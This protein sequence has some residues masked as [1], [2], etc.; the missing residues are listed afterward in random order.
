MRIGGLASGMDTDQLVSELMKA[1][2]MPLDKLMQNKV[3]TEWQRDSFREFNL[4][5]SN[6]RA[7]A[8]DLRFQSTF[9]A[10]SAT[11]SNTSSMTATTTANAVNGTYTA[12]V[13]SV[14]SPAKMHSAGTINNSTGVPANSTDLIGTA[15]TIKVNIN[16]GTTTNVDITADMTY[17]DV[18]KKLQDITAGTATELR[19][20]FDNTTSRFFISTKGMGATQNFSIDFINSDGTP[21]ANLANQVIGKKN[22]MDAD[23]TTYSTSTAVAGSFMTAAINGEVEFDGITVNNLTSNKTTINGITLNLLQTGTSTITVQSDTTKSLESIKSFVEKYNETIASVEKKLVEKRYPDF[24]PLSDE[25]KKDMSE[26]EIELWEEKARSGL[27]RNDP[28]LKNA[29]QDLRRAFMDPVQGIASGNI[30]LLSQIGIN[31]GSYT[32]GGKLFINED[33]LKEALT[34]KPD[35]VMQLFTNKDATGNGLGIG[36]RVYQK[37][38]EVVKNLSNQAGSPATSVDN[39]IISKKI[40]QMSEEIS[41]WQDRLK[42]TENRYWRQFTAMEKAISQA[43]S[44]STWMQQNMFGG[45]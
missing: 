19:A 37:L 10:Y 41:N 31:T 30:S 8:S 7:S 5:L 40:K 16:G 34:N 9:N 3:W 12:K 13:V 35:E 11:S 22:A 1:K 4:S 27:L 23:V 32:E 26:K 44:Q 33:K 25:Q 14:A 45:M 15:G 43:N 29:I 2:K 18:A 6:L 28:I 36:D 21:N 42:M 39:S 24:K 38:N 17:A 20:S